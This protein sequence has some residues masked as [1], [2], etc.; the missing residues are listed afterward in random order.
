M[1]SCL[2]AENFLKSKDELTVPEKL[3]RMQMLASLNDNAEK[4]FAHIFL[5]FDRRDQ[6]TDENIVD[7]AGRYMNAA[8]F[9]RQPYL[10]YRHFDT[11]HPHAHIVSTI[12]S[13]SGDLIDTSP[14]LL[15]ELRQLS[16]KWEQEYSLVP[17]KGKHTT[18]VEGARRNYA[19]R[20]DYGKS[21]LKRSI[22]EI[23]NTVFDHYKYKNLE[24]YNALLSE[25]NIRADRGNEGT[26]LHKNG[27]LVYAALDEEGTRISRGIKASSFSTKPTLANLERKFALNASY[28]E[29]SQERVKFAVDWVLSDTK[30][31][32]NG[33]ED[34]L[35]QEGFNV[36]VQKKHGSSGSEIFFIDHGA[37]T[38]FSGQSLGEQYSLES[39]QQRLVKEVEHED[40]LVERHHLR[41]RL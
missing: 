11:W 3:D 2:V 13:P 38:I 36:V 10:I 34:S 20:L 7:L 41:L 8:G 18:N 21:A 4:R 30:K 25:Y 14:K 27:G 32:W 24:E 23:T 26:K 29:S 16:D 12:V 15:K 28:A 1:A 17:Y 9:G 19:K 5:T 39:I 33:F 35:C 31:D 40:T 37:K 6:L 22:Y